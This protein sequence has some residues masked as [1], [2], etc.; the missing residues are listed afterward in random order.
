MIADISG[1]RR[2]GSSGAPTNEIGLSFETRRMLNELREKR[3]YLRRRDIISDKKGYVIIE[4]LVPKEDL[5]DTTGGE[6]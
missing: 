4:D 3:E 5:P 1:G 6:P 2:L